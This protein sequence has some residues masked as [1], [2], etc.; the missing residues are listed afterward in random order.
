[1][2]SWR[3]KQRGENNRWEVRPVSLV[4][5][6][7]RSY[8]TDGTTPHLGPGGGGRITYGS[9]NTWTMGKVKAHGAFMLATDGWAALES[10]CKCV[11]GKSL[12]QKYNLIQLSFIIHSRQSWLKLNIQTTKI[13]ASG[14]IT[15][16]QIDGET[17]ET[18]TDFILGA[19]KSLQMVTIAMKLKDASSLE[20]KLW[21]T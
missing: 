1:M 15:S 14:P 6:S 12:P 18:V 7:A 3:S 5:M 20:E 17:M 16:W 11:S 21:P 19:P 13:M 8:S 2:H 9:L 10:Q 4:D